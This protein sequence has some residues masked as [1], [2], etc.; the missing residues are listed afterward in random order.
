MKPYPWQKKQWEKI[1]TS[2]QA[3]KIPHALLLIGPQGL[4]KKSFANA[5]AYDLFCESKI[6]QI[7]CGKCGACHLLKNNS[8]P[9]LK[10]V[11]LVDKKQSIGIDQI[12]ALIEYVNLTPHS[13]KRKIIIIENAESMTVQASN[14]LLKTLEEPP[15]SAIIILVTNRPDRL[16]ATIRSRCQTI[17]FSPPEIDLAESWLQEKLKSKDQIKPLLAFAN[18]APLLA[19][20]FAKQNVLDERNALF[21]DLMTISQGQTNIVKVAQSWLKKDWDLTLYCLTG[22]VV[23]MIRLKLSPKPPGLSNPDLKQAML[24]LNQPG[25]LKSQLIFYQHLV[26]LNEMKLAN[27][28]VQLMLED[29]L[30]RWKKLTTT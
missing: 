3:G 21:S 19:E 30:I 17:E 7:A 8:H 14:S 27:I 15:P 1:Q 4:G 6:N 28:N 29:T 22:W 18:N 16:L 23:D 13:A 12:R 11:N 2:I 5:I 9:D 26:E 10:Q 20:Q 25:S 24:K